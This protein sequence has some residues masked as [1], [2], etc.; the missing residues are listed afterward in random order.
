VQRLHPAEH[1]IRV[2]MTNRGNALW[3]GAERGLAVR[4]PE[5]KLFLECIWAQRRAAAVRRKTTG[6]IGLRQNLRELLAI[7]AHVEIRSVRILDRGVKVTKTSLF[8]AW[9][10]LTESFLKPDAPNVAAIR[11]WRSGAAVAHG[12]FD[13]ARSLLQAN[14]PDQLIEESLGR[15]LERSSLESLSI[16]TDW[17]TSADPDKTEL[18]VRAYSHAAP[19]KQARFLSHL[20]RAGVCESRALLE[21]V[22]PAAE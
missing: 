10:K 18:A 8:D 15:L 11:V 4:S 7:R 1:R 13:R 3:Y 9:S 21:A 5:L 20:D 12:D 14:E 17:L 16:L 22:S 19:E 2:R 6:A